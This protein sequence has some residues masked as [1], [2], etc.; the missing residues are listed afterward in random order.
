MIR[1][2]KTDDLIYEYACHE[3]NYAMDGILGGAR[4]RSQGEEKVSQVVAPRD[5]SGQGPCDSTI[6]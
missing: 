4:R 3:G 1:L 2:K 6:G 5:W